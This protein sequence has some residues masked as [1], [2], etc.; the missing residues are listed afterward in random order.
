MSIDVTIYI[1][2]EDIKGMF[3]EEDSVSSSLFLTDGFEL[4]FTHEAIYEFYIKLKERMED[5]N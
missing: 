2:K 1:D 5:E 3:Q 4:R